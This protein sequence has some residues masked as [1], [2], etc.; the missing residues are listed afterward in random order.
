MTSQKRYLI[1]TSDENTW[2]F[3]RPVLFLSEWCRLYNRKHIW[4]HM[5]AVVADPYGLNHLKRDKDYS[6]SLKLEYKLFPKFIQ[7]LNKYHNTNYSQR[8]K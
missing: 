6:D 4:H 7:L 8:F 1:T 2:K 5:N 3:D